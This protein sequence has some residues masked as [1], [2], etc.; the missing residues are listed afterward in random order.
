M[1]MSLQLLQLSLFAVTVTSS[2]FSHV[3]IQ[4]PNDVK[5]CGR[6]EQLLHEIQA[7]MTQMQQDIARLSAGGQ[8]ENT[9]S[10]L[11]QGGLRD[12]AVNFSLHRNLQQHRE[13]FTDKARLS[14]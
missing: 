3:I 11:P 5:S 4:Q 1:K 13:V 8:F 9:K 14:Y 6:N 12:A 7:T 10:M 2:Q